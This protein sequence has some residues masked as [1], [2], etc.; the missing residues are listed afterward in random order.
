[1]AIV[2]GFVCIERRSLSTLW[3]VRRESFGVADS[4]HSGGC[5][6]VG[7][8]LCRRGGACRGRGVHGL[9]VRLRGESSRRGSA[10]GGLDPAGARARVAHP[11]DFDDLRVVVHQR[12]KSLEVASVDGF[13]G[14]QARSTFSRDIVYSR[15]PTASRASSRS[16]KTR[17]LAT[18]PPAKS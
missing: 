18:L 17:M 2:A 15:R 8:A 12:Q 5:S 4:R 14:S 11:H 13:E 3:T 1:V 6:R 9:A 16:R 10:A 7:W